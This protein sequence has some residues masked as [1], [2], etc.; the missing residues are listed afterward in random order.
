VHHPGNRG[1]SDRRAVRSVG[2]RRAGLAG[3]GLTLF[4]ISFA[5]A[6]P[7]GA[8]SDE[9]DQ[10]VKAV[11]A[12][13]LD[14]VGVKVS[15]A[16][17]R[18]MDDWLPAI[19]RILTSYPAFAEL[20][21]SYV[22]PSSL[23]PRYLGCTVVS[24]VASCLDRPTPPIPTTSEPVVSSVGSYPPYIYLPA[25]LVMRAASGT[26]AALLLGRITFALIAALLLFGALLVA[27][28]ARPGPLTV[29]FILLCVAPTSVL[30]MSGLNSSG[31]ESAAGIAW[32]VALLAASEP[33]PPR[34]AWWLALA[35][36]LVCGVARSTG[37][38]WLVLM[39]VVVLIFRGPRASWA[40]FRAGGKVAI[41]AVAICVV[42]GIAT[43]GWQLAVQ[44]AYQESLAPTLG[45][46]S[47]SMIGFILSRAI[48]A[49][50]WGEAAPSPLLAQVWGLL[51]AAL[52]A[53]GVVTAVRRRAWREVASLVA[54]CVAVVVLIAGF[55]AFGSHA[56]M[57]QGR[58]FL[59]PLAG[60][61]IVAGWMSSTRPNHVGD[62][63]TVRMVSRVVVT[64][65]ASCLAIFWWA[66]EYRYAADG[67]S[68]LFLGHSLWQPPLGWAPWLVCG[69]LG[70]VAMLVAGLGG[71]P[72]ERA[73]VDPESAA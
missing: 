15:T 30:V 11:A 45:N 54:I 43:L 21:R 42:A 32:W 27:L 20:A 48:A 50:G 22:I 36:G 44:P 72:V 16:E 34:G 58:W 35:A 47:P 56:G 61:P 13:H 26:T 23:D 6:N 1:V 57:I 7:P 73:A 62:E 25:G 66:N 8:V 33:H 52:V 53:L 51:A 67:G 59:A 10:Y 19:N 39:T 49:F 14:L 37:P 46:A 55:L 71:S 60:I 68:L 2:A 41:A 65:T 9:P 70:L 29:A 3:L 63:R 12:G 40:A 18:S 69:I 17:A 31:P 38:V 4:L 28:R 5:G 64:V 24:V